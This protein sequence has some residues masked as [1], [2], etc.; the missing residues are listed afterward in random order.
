MKTISYH[1][2]CARRTRCTLSAPTDS[3]QLVK[4]KAS[5]FHHPLCDETSVKT[6]SIQ[7]QY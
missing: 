1:H 2:C 7:M 6:I 3:A 4:I 5:R